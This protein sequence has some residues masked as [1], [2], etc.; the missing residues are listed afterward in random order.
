M[1][2]PLIA[3]DNQPRGSSDKLRIKNEQP[4]WLTQQ[5]RPATSIASPLKLLLVKPYQKISAPT[6]SPPLGLLYIVSNLRR[7]LGNQVEIRVLDMKLSNWGPEQIDGVLKE[8]DPDVVGFSALNY[9]AYAGHCIAERVK[10]F[11]PSIITAFGGPYALKNAKPIL[12]DRHID[13]VFEG[14]ADRSFP[15]ALLRKVKGEQPG[16]DIPGMSF[17]RPDGSVFLSAAQDQINE[18]DVL[19]PPAWDLIDFDAYAQKI[20][21]AHNLRSKRY[22]M[23]FTSRGCPYLCNYC[24]DLFSKKFVYHSVDYVIAEIEQLYE[25]YGVTEF[26]IVDDIF[27]LHKPRLQAIMAT[28]QQRWPGKMKFTFPNG[29]RAD[30]LDEDVINALADAGTYMVCVAIESVTPRIQTLVEKHL[31]IEKTKKAIAL[32]QKRDIQVNGFFMLGFPTETQEEIQ[33]TIDFAVDSDLT[34][35]HFF[36]VVPQPGTPV[37]DLAVKQAE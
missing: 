18:L 12:E 13:W 34:M 6:Y 23:L 1:S 27:N 3:S 32:M 31:D 28:V 9:E 33:A 24:H 14:S 8:F 22:A 11:N 35:A 19:P 20:N 17:R 4:A 36:L 16:G 29:L 15:E 37:S 7:V 5:A 26:Q 2:K 30:I 21:M 10:N 25:R